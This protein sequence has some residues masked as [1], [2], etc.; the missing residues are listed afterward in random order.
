MFAR[1]AAIHHPDVHTW[2][3]PDREILPKSYER[4]C[5]AEK[6]RRA[7]GLAPRGGENA[8]QCAANAQI[9]MD[10]VGGPIPGWSRKRWFQR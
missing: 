6:R 7:I 9:P 1:V 8:D 3:L 10:G 2:F 4:D 5:V